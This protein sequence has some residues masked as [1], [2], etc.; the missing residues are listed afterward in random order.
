[1]KLYLIQV[2]AEALEWIFYISLE[3]AK[4]RGGGG[5]EAGGRDLARLLAAGLLGAA[6]AMLVTRAA[7][8]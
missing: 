4:V 1:M 5:G 8:P 7:R 2:R 3:L 6:A